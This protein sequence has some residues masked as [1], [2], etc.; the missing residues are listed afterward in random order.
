MSEERKQ[1]MFIVA[2]EGQN[3]ADQVYDTLRDLQ[4]EKRVKI[5]TAAVVTRKENGKL[6]LK[7]KRRLTVGKGAVGGGLLSVL[8]VGT[9]GGALIIGAA[10]G[11]LLGSSRSKW[12]KEVKEFLDN[13]LGQDESALA[14]LISDAD[15]AAVQIATEQYGG[16]VLKVELTSDAEERL[17]VLASDEAVAKAVAEE[18]ETEDDP[19]VEEVEETS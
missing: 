17:N 18:V 15:W 5:K 16:D 1:S 10:V 13:K 2:Y 12:R 3:T 4:K 6:K 11:A 7:H 8:I 19:E 9:G 14:I